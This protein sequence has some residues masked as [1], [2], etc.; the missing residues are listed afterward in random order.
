M[1]FQ[2]MN[3]YS[4]A[5]NRTGC[6][7]VPHLFEATGS[8]SP[9]NILTK[10]F[11]QNCILAVF[12]SAISSFADRLNLVPKNALLTLDSFRSK[13]AKR[14]IRMSCFVGKIEYISNPYNPAQLPTASS[15]ASGDRLSRELSMLAK[16]IQ[17][18]G[19]MKTNKSERPNYATVLPYI[20]RVHPMV[21]EAGP[22]PR[23]EVYDFG[24][25]R[26]MCKLCQKVNNSRKSSHPKNTQ[27]CFLSS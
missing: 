27:P 13:V 10:K 23:A 7:A 24:A 25:P 2:Y 26:G 1:L 18:E 5:K 20:H 9:R 11:P 4:V 8:G 17:I 3:D 22:A 16:L 14:R 21:E 19:S 6:E 15:A 12:H